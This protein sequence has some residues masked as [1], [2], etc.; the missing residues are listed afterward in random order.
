VTVIAASL[1]AAELGARWIELPAM[2]LG[3]QLA[4]QVSPRPG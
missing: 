4:A 2:R 3:K 1:A